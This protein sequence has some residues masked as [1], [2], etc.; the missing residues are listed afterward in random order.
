MD[1]RAIQRVDIGFYLM[2]PAIVLILDPCPLGLPEVW[3][4]AHINNI[5]LKPGF[6]NPASLP[7]PPARGKDS[8][9]MILVFHRGF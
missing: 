4:V 8:E 1:S 9:G 3:T 2:G 7:R 5:S 6:W